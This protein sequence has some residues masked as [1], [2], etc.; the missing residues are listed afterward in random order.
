LYLES[1]AA[2]FE[3]RFGFHYKAIAPPGRPLDFPSKQFLFKLEIKGPDPFFS[4][5]DHQSMRQA[6]LVLQKIKDLTKLQNT[7]NDR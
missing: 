6:I 2:W 7:A 1:A 3:I 5:I 4:L